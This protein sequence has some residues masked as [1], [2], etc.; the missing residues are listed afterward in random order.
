MSKRRSFILLLIFLGSAQIAVACG[1]Y[2]RA[3][4]LGEFEKSD[5]V[6]IARIVSV[7]PAIP[8]KEIYGGHVPSAHMVVDRVLKGSVK[9]NDTLLFAQGDEILGCSWSFDKEMIGNNYLLYLYTPDKS[10]DPWY[11][12]TCTRSRGLEYAEEDLRYL[13]NMDQLRGR[14]RVSGVLEDEDADDES[15]AGRKIRIIGKKRTYTVTTDKN[16]LYELKESKSCGCEMTF[17]S[18]RVTAGTPPFPDRCGPTA[19][20]RP[21]QDGSTFCLRSL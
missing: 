19:R 13:N 18:S 3:T 17:N 1:C 5:V 16:G 10:S 21:R 20:R 12:S 8:P 2:P 11:V 15:L 4:V 9:V 14:T 7:E 6:V